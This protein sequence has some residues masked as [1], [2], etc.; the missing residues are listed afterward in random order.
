MKWL[1]TVAEPIVIIYNQTLLF[2]EKMPYFVSSPPNSPG[3]VAT[4]RWH[5][6]A[7]LDTSFGADSQ[8]PPRFA[9]CTYVGSAT[10]E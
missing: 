7:S 9:Q 3:R 8:Y 4:D 10:S 1:V 5:S 6:Y 2:D